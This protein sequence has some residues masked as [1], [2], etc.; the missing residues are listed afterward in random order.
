MAL[1]RQIAEQAEETVRS[2]LSDYLR[3]TFGFIF[4]FHKEQPASLDAGCSFF[5][6]RAA[7]TLRSGLTPCVS[8]LFFRRKLR[9]GKYFFE[10]TIVYDII[11]YEI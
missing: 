6:D 1:A 9:N 5:Q 8:E 2:Q 10:N 3:Q 4:S 7:G 11:F